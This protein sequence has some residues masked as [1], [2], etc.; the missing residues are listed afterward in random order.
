MNPKLKTKGTDTEVF[1]KFLYRSSKVQCS[2]PT[3]DA[4]VVTDTLCR[5]KDFCNH[6]QIGVE[7]EVFDIDGTVKAQFD[8]RRK[9]EGDKQD[10]KAERLQTW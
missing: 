1:R 4:C 3:A 10:L 5:K 7:D 6:V 9:Y 8:W 2:V